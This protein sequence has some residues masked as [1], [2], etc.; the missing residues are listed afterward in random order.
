MNKL[1]GDPIVM[2]IA[3]D[4]GAISISWTRPS[5]TT[6]LE[7]TYHTTTLSREAIE[8]DADMLYYFKELNSDAVEFLMAHARAK[9]S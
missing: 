3:F 7:S 4:E 2:Q 8:S 1:S 5:E 6:E 9:A